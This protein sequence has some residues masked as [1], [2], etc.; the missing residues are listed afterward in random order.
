MLWQIIRNKSDPSGEY[1]ENYLFVYDRSAM[2]GWSS[3]EQERLMS[4]SIPSG[5][6]PTMARAAEVREGPGPDRVNDH[7]G[8]DRTARPA[9]A[10]PGMGNVIDKT[11]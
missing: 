10:P 4:I 11:A 6:A 3:T 8:D 1:F 2:V 7:D 9:A 5:S